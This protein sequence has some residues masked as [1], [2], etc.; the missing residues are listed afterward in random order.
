MDFL[1]LHKKSYFSFAK[2]I[3]VTKQL[4]KRYDNNKATLEKFS[5]HAK[6]I[7]YLV[8]PPFEAFKALIL[9]APGMFSTRVLRNLLIFSL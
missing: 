9:P 8:C 7:Q 6:V 1:F 3:R 4:E 5:S 2:S